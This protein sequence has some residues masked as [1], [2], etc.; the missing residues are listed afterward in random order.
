VLLSRASKE[1]R[2][3]LKEIS[4][5]TGA[6]RDGRWDDSKYLRAPGPV[7]GNQNWLDNSAIL[8]PQDGEL[9]FRGGGQAS[10]SG[11]KLPPKLHYANNDYVGAFVFTPE[12]VVLGS[13][14]TSYPAQSDGSRRV[15]RIGSSSEG[16]WEWHEWMVP[17]DSS[18]VRRWG[19]WLGVTV[20]ESDA[21][22][23]NGRFV[24]G[25]PR[26]SP[27]QHERRREITATGLPW[28]GDENYYPGT[29]LLYNVPTREQ[30]TIHTGQGDSE[31]LL[32]ESNR[33]YYRAADRIYRAR[34]G[35]RAS[36]NIELLVKNPAV[37]DVHW[38]FRSLR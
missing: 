17:G 21:I 15:F 28:S 12:L 32:V 11:L 2:Y 33:V 29:L 13:R 36:S 26:I 8:F 20:G 9:V 35:S 19:K 38:M 37:N 3:V 25:K 16:R 10:D 18:R 14:D 7:G 27:G 5:A 30:Y 4:L 22:I 31:I 34:I 23:R 6:T 1:G 24:Q